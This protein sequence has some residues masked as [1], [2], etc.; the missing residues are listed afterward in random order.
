MEAAG[1]I[2]GIVIDNNPTSSS[3]TSPMFS[4]SGDGSNDVTIPVVFLFA[5]DAQQLIKAHEEDPDLEVVLAERVE[6]KG[7]SNKNII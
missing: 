5:K 2:G 7:K 4:M 3:K 1:A 6:T